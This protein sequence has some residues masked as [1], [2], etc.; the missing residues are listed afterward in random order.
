MWQ[1]RG[2]TRNVH[3]QRPVDGKPPRGALIGAP[4]NHRACAPVFCTPIDE[5]FCA[6][7]D[8][9]RRHEPTKVLNR[10]TF[11]PPITRLSAERESHQSSGKFAR[12]RRH[13]PQWGPTQPF[14]F[15]QGG[16]AQSKRRDRQGV[17]KNGGIQATAAQQFSRGSLGRR[18][19][20]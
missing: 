9:G 16:V 2:M 5:N 20:P 10:L 12:S 19:N 8:L 3:F 15:G 1:S 13:F 14:D 18:K 7:G 4:W 11:L 6:S 17:R